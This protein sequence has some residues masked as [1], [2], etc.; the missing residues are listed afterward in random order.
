MPQSLNADGDT[1]GR[2]VS[3]RGSREGARRPRARP[4]HGPGQA[5]RSHWPAMGACTARHGPGAHAGRAS[6]RGEWE[7]GW[8]D[9]VGGPHAGDDAAGGTASQWSL[10]LGGAGS[11]RAEVAVHPARLPGHRRSRHLGKGRPEGV[12]GHPSSGVLG[13]YASPGC[14]DGTRGGPMP[15]VAVLCT[16]LPR[17]SRRSQWA[18][19]CRGQS[20]PR[21]RPPYRAE[22]AARHIPYWCPERRGRR[23]LPPMHSPPLPLAPPPNAA[24]RRIRASPSAGPL[25]SEGHGARG[26]ATPPGGGPDDSLAGP[27]HE[28]PQATPSPEYADGYRGATWNAHGLLGSAAS[29]ML[30]LAVTTSSGYRRRTPWRPARRGCCCQAGWSPCGLM[31]PAARGGVALL[32][33]A[34]FLRRFCPV[35]QGDWEE[36]VPGR[37]AALHLR[38]LGESLSVAVAYFE[39]GSADHAG[40]SD[41]RR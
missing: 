19:P 31:A 10:L 22:V 37:L 1:S 36:V 15:G 32:V 27:S 2:L 24:V 34:A 26:G 12:T 16:V 3:R 6:H 40:R 23:N 28:G 35:A 7:R 8:R 9:V 14:M 21:R 39:S 33:Q 4:P 29:F 13:P 25:G 11:Q 38:G 17:N 41:M 30:C 5:D 18:P 20:R